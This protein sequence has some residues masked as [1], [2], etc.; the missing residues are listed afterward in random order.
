MREEEREGK[1]KDSAVKNDA[2]V[3]GLGHFA[4]G[5]SDDYA[6]KCRTR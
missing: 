6:K 2:L 1:V 5:G 4:D 3:S